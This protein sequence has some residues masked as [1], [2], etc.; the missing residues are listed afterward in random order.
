MFSSL[1]YTMDVAYQKHLFISQFLFLDI[2]STLDVT[3]DIHV[4]LM[5]LF[6][7]TNGQSQIDIWINPCALS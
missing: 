3:I 2:C 7:P 1:S 5:M 6:L 4:L